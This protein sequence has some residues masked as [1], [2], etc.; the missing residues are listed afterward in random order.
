MPVSILKCPL[1]QSIGMAHQTIPS[2]A[3]YALTQMYK[4]G[5]IR[6]QDCYFVPFIVVTTLTTAPS[7]FT[8]AAKPIPFPPPPSNLEAT[9][10]EDLRE[11]YFGHAMLNISWVGPKGMDHLG[12]VGNLLKLHYTMLNNVMANSMFLG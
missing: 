6:R 2:H 12:L 11:G 7:P 1:Q 10:S 8:T 4:V 9:W 5:T 3:K